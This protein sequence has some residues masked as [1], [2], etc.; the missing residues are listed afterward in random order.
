MLQF[1]IVLELR[2]WKSGS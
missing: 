1:M 2:R